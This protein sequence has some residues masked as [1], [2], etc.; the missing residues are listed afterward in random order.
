MDSGEHPHTDRIG[1]SEAIQCTLRD[2]NQGR[3]NAQGVPG[4][5]RKDAAQADTS[6][7]TAVCEKARN[8][9]PHLGS[10]RGTRCMQPVQSR[11]DPGVDRRE[12]EPHAQTDRARSGSG[13]PA[14]PAR[15][16]RK[17]P[18]ME[19]RGSPPRMQHA[20]S[21]KRNQHDRS[22]ALN[23]PRRGQERSENCAQAQAANKQNRRSKP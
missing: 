4:V 7:H 17:T 23:E 21:G 13:D 12:A 14:R 10:G 6:D 16:K 3:G 22:K 15:T 2:T 18:E 5:R 11:A 19:R 9:T 1:G 8:A 20:G